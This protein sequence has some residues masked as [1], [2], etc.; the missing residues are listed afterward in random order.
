[1]SGQLQLSS[2]IQYLKLDLIS[3]EWCEWLPVLMLIPIKPTWV[4]VFSLKWERI[5]R[6][7]FPG[8]KFLNGFDVIL[9]PVDIILL[10]KVTLPQCKISL[11]HYPAGLILATTRLRDRLGWLRRFWELDHTFVG[12][13]ADGHW[14]IHSLH[15]SNTFYAPDVGNLHQLPSGTIRRVV[16]STISRDKVVSAPSSVDLQAIYKIYSIE[17]TSDLLLLPLVFST[18]GWCKRQLHLNELIQL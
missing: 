18:I 17:N 8:A 5:L 10:R 16:N 12:G 7:C 4:W 6:R 15:R 2:E 1:M 14:R 13:C 9:P 11:D 3:L